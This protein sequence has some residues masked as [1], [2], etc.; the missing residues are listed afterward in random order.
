MVAYNKDAVNKAIGASRAKIGGREAKAIHA[1]LKG[2]GPSTPAPPPPAPSAAAKSPPGPP[3]DMPLK[4]GGRAKH[5]S[6]GKVSGSIP[7]VRRVGPIKG[8]AALRHAGR[9]QRGGG[10]GCCDTSPLSSAKTGTPA[11]GRSV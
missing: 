11:T 10:G 1:L 3:A 4:K 6:G 7:D 8:A 9:S 5:A 2:R